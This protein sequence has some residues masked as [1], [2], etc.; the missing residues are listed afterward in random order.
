MEHKKRTLTRLLVMC[1]LI[2]SMAGCYTHRY[3]YETP[4]L[5]IQKTYNRPF[6]PT[7]GTFE[8]EKE[9]IMGRSIQEMQ[10]TIMD[11]EKQVEDYN[12]FA[13]DINSKLNK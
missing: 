2:V 4:K 6:V 3:H 1:V 9:V 11:Y 5:P 13:R 8:T 10:K 7:Y 12:N